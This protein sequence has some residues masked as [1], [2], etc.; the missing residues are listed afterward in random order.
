MCVCDF[1]FCI[2]R[3]SSQRAK[4][5][6]EN[7]QSS[8]QPAIRRAKASIYI[9]KTKIKQ[10]TIHTKMHID[11]SKSE[12]NSSSHVCVCAFSTHTHK[13]TRTKIHPSRTCDKPRRAEKYSDAAFCYMLHSP[14]LP[15][16]GVVM[17]M[18]CCWFYVWVFASPQLLV[19][20][21]IVFYLFF[22]FR[23]GWVAQ[24]KSGSLHF[25]LCASLHIYYIYIYDDDDANSFLARCEFYERFRSRLVFW[26]RWGWFLF[27]F[28]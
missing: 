17:V 5:C 9:A 20:L 16:N 26:M 14:R 11:V 6:I 2:N 10:H 23:F 27:D 24:S 1:F 7:T 21:C 12:R 22:F 3:A 8:K 28:S 15:L 25:L 13:H 4:K 19:S 18:V